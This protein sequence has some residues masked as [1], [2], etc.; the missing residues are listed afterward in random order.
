LILQSVKQF[1]KFVT[2]GSVSNGLIAWLFGVTGPLL[3]VLQAASQG[4]LSSTEV[5]SWIFGIYVV[6]GVITLLQAF[7]FRQPIGYAF[8]IPGAVL[9]GATLAHRPFSQVIGAY[10]IT[11]ALILLLGMTGVVEKVMRVLPMPVMMGMVSGVLLPFGVGLF[12]SVISSP[13]LNG[14]PLLVFLILSFVPGISRKFPPILGVIFTAAILLIVMH[15][16]HLVGT[17]VSMAMP[18]IYTPTWNIATIGQLVLPLVL[19]VI[20]IDRKSV[21]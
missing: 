7:V 13:V 4:H 12:K 1:P 21:V 19:T 2:L 14:I 8:S 3:I 5:T 11:G 16:I 10:L 17:S 9:I 6:P 18:H 20:A 15:R